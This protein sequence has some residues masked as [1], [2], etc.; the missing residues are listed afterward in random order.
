MYI[1]SDSSGGRALVI[2]FKEG[3][4][5]TNLMVWSNNVVCFI[6]EEALMGGIR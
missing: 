5:N 6:R 4:I 3:I 2:A 1:W